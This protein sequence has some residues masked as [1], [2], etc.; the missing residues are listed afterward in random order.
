MTPEGYAAHLTQEKLERA[1]AEHVEENLSLHARCNELE[2]GL[3]NLVTA[4]EARVAD[5]EAQLQTARAYNTT[6]VDGMRSRA[7]EAEAELAALRERVNG[8]PRCGGV[9]D[10]G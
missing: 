9:V 7:L 6:C 4:S 8:C 3:Q 2:E 10:R 5:L 1:L